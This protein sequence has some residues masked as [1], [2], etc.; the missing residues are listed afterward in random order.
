MRG[1]DTRTHIQTG[2]CSTSGSTCLLHLLW[3]ELEKRDKRTSLYKLLHD[4]INVE[5]CSSKS[6]HAGSEF[7]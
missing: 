4:C 7:G 1:Q 5:W 6:G 2:V 3:S